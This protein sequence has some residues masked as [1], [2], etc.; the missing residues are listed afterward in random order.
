M[1][2]SQSLNTDLWRDDSYEATVTVEGIVG[3][4]IFSMHTTAPLQDYE[5]PTNDREIVESPTNPA[6][7]SDRTFFD[8]LYALTLQEIRDCSVSHISDGSFDNG[9]PLPDESDKEEFKGGFFETGFLWKYVWTRDISYSVDLGLAVIDSTR[10]LNSL[11]FKLSERREGGGD[12]QIV[13]DTGTGGSY[14]ISSDRVVWSFGVRAL[15]RQLQGNERSNF[16]RDAYEALKNTIEHDRQV[17]FDQEDGLYRGEESFLDWREQSYPEW[18]AEAPVQIGM[19]KALSTNACHLSSLL[20]AASLAGELGDSAAQQKYSQWAEEL[21][22]T[23]RKHLYLPDKQLYSAFITTTLD[24]SPAYQYDLLGNALAILIDIANEQQAERIVAQ[25]PHLAKGAP[26]IWPQQQFRR[27]QVFWQNKAYKPIYHNRAIWPFVTAYWLRAAKKV[28]NDAAVTHGVQSLIRGTALSLSNM[29]NFDVVSGRVQVEEG[30]AVNSPRQLWSVAGYLSMVHEI[31]FGLSWRDS[32][33]AIAPY[34]TRELHHTL[35]S[36][37]RQLVLD[38]LPYRGRQ[39]KIIV[40][41]PTL[42]NERKGA[43]TVGQIRLNGRSVIGEITESML[44]NSNEIQVDLVDG[45]VE[46]SSIVLVDES[47]YANNYRG[48]YAPYP[49]EIEQITEIDGKL[50]IHFNV[51]YEQANELTIN[52]YRDG[53]LVAENIPGDSGVW[54]DPD[55]Q[56]IESPSYCY[57][58]ESVYISSGTISQRARPFCYWG[59]NYNRI[60]VVSANQFEYSGGQLSNN[61]GKF[62]I[63]HWG[64]NDDRITVNVKAQFSGFHAI[65]VL[66]GNGAGDINTGITCGVK[67]LQMRDL[68][69]DKLVADG[70]LLMPHLGKD[71]WNRWLESSFIFTQEVGLIKERNYQITIL[72]DDRNINSGI[73]RAINMSSFKHYEKYTGGNGGQNGPYN[74]VNIAEV[75]LLWLNKSG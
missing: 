39:L 58:L 18:T 19:S 64:A 73:A 33:I 29:E 25:Y 66:A 24:L 52:I 71:S 11:K 63:E 2:N 59:Q 17:I 27:E 62:H 48:L 8:A 36:K 37:S 38:R 9:N 70:Y 56:G 51:N 69:E 40:N 75:K 60:Y 41:L 4:R 32:G 57:T 67:R 47:E 26:V 15:L 23:I 6:V 68:E 72:S 53:K 3:T 1:T 65:Q 7:Q 46:S 12:L 42:T 30:P 35:F 54:E 43:Y 31:I 55:T 44:A 5:Y 14:P 22:Q 13:Q 74:Y 34:I 49:P 10:A 21:R 16:A 28:K 20:L 50:Q 45:N 61:H